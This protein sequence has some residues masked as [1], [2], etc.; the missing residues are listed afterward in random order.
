MHTST[1][2]QQTW[3]H[4]WVFRCPNVVWIETKL[5]CKRFSFEPGLN[6]PWHPCQE[7]NAGWLV[8]CN[9][10]TKDKQNMCILSLTILICIYLH[11]LHFL[12][13]NCCILL[14]WSQV[15]SDL[16]NGSKTTQIGDLQINNG[17]FWYFHQK[18]KNQMLLDIKPLVVCYRNDSEFLLF[19]SLPWKLKPMPKIKY[20]HHTSQRDPKR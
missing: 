17:F 2:V 10:E 15:D 4:F 18:V 6:Q 12:F 13:L 3:A 8:I 19:K 14:L 11:V 20:I 1:Y 7:F 16:S 5:S 9:I